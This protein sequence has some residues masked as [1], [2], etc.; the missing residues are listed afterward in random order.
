MA[1]KSESA[2]I[3]DEGPKTLLFV[4]V[5]RGLS[6]GRNAVLEKRHHNQFR[7]S[8]ADQQGVQSSLGLFHY[9]VFHEDD[10]GKEE[11]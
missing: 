7:L 5:F 9:Y 6:I 4:L 11:L 2:R 8:H 1:E 3:S 10:V